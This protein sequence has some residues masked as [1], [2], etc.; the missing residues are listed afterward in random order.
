M[1][2]VFRSDERPIGDEFLGVPIKVGG[3]VYGNLYLTDKIGYAEFTDDDV[4]AV[5][6]LASAASV[7]IENGRLQKK[8]HLTAVTEVGV[9]IG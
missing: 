5:E 6:T 4:V 9:N 8:L 3:E 1:P 2:S 7:A